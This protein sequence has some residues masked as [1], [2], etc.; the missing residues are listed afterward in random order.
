MISHFIS[1]I[2]VFISL[3]CFLED[4]FIFFLAISVYFCIIGEGVTGREQPQVQKVTQAGPKITQAGPK[5]HARAKMPHWSVINNDF[6][7]P[8]QSLIDKSGQENVLS[9][10][11]KY[12]ILEFSNQ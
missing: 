6:E 7:S 8:I 1:F 9:N 4:P 12:F 3:T 11:L 10:R 2:W 5:S